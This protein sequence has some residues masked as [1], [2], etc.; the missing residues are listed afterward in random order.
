[1]EG[2]TERRA[3]MI[4]GGGGV[5]ERNNVIYWIPCEYQKIKRQTNNVVTKDKQTIKQKMEK[6]RLKKKGK[7]ELVVSQGQQQ[8]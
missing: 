6:I 2:F 3:P 5:T 8:R 1:M 4:R 7:R